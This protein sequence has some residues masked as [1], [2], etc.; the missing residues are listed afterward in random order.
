[1]LGGASRMFRPDR[2][3][4]GQLLGISENAGKGIIRVRHVVS[5]EP[6]DH[7][8]STSLVTLK[9]MITLSLR[10]AMISQAM[11]HGNK[12]AGPK[13]KGNGILERIESRKDCQDRGQTT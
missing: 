4:G 13:S 1:M 5:C 3:T 12:D 2:G 7:D 10:V 9:W 6:D 11:K 8:P